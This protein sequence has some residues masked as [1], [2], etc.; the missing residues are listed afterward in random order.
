MAVLTPTQL[1]DLVSIPGGLRAD[2]ATLYLPTGYGGPVNAPLIA[3][4]T[5]R[6]C[7]NWALCAGLETNAQ[8][9]STPER[10]YAHTGMVNTNTGGAYTQL[11]VTYGTE[12]QLETLWADAAAE[13]PDD[14]TGDPP[15][16]L[17]M[18][19]MAR[20]AARSSGLEPSAGA[21]PYRLHVTT[22]R[23]QWYGW[24]HWGLCSRMAETRA[25]CRRTPAI[26]CTGAGI[27]CGRRTRRA[28]SRRASICASSTTG[29]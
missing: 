22:T 1:A 16:L 20:V 11:Q 9:D 10:L 3:N 19:A 6:S 4:I 29:T 23:A 18:Q 12:P 14:P 25:S 8:R 27:A 2:S 28:S 7:W 21:T 24:M 15:R 5:A 17:F 13:V 26:R